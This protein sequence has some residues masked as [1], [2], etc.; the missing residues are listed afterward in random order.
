MRDTL[1]GIAARLTDD[2][3][4]RRVRILATRER[5]ATVELVAHL[6][7]LDTRKLHLAQGYGSLFSYCTEALRLA[8]HAAYNR[9]EAARA[10]RQFPSVLDRLADGSLNL[11]TLRLLTPHLTPENH[12]SVLDQAARKSKRE[13]EALVARLAPRPDVPGSV[14]KL[15]PPRP[16][17]QAPAVPA[18][19]GTAA[20][21]AVATTDTVT[22]AATVINTVT[23]AT[24]GSRPLVAP[25]SPERYRVQFTVGPETHE[26]LRR[27]QEL[28]RREIPDG[29]PA[30]IFDRALKLLL[31]D[32]AREKFAATSKP[33][34]ER[35]TAEGSRHIP[36][37]VKRAIW[38]RDGGQCAFV[39]RSGR[40]C[41]Q[42]AILEFHHVD[43]YAIG[44]EATVANVSLRCRAHNVH[45]AERLFGSFAPVRTR[46]LADALP[47]WA[48][49]SPRGELRTGQLSSG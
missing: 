3:L 37:R 11:S 13:V 41:R 40:R 20:P 39:A 19:V 8:E 24:A 26:N 14:R 23:V 35:P 1:L 25:L 6:A 4:F 46:R 18:A 16:L 22:N 31:E 36:A 29:D 33:R 44:G 9:I 27:A 38:L 5:A 12:Q 21:V 48:G 47:E 10:S 30:T 17:L 49:D 32:I 45:E 2:E 34:P 28:L 43:P 15:P 42:R 7:E